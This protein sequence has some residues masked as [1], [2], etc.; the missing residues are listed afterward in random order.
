MAKLQ[1][2]GLS[3]GILIP[4]N[5]PFFDYDYKVKVSTH[6]ID[7]RGWDWSGEI[8]RDHA[9]LYD[10][11]ASAINEILIGKEVSNSNRFRVT[12]QIGL[13]YQ[14]DALDQG[15]DSPI[16]GIVYG[17]LFT[18][19]SSVLRYEMNDCGIGVMGNY[20][21]CAIPSWDGYEAT[22]RL[23]L[24]ILLFKQIQIQSIDTPVYALSLEQGINPEAYV[25]QLAAGCFVRDY[26][27]LADK[28]FQIPNC[29]RYLSKQRRPAFKR[30]SAPSA[31]ALATQGFPST[32]GRMASAFHPAEWITSKPKCKAKY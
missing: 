5:F 31:M 29:R 26:V 2:V 32:K 15:G 17:C 27:Q 25:A 16:G 3:F 30:I 24:S 22:D 1:K 14:L 8:Q 18:D 7:K 28:G 12:P 4:I 6:Q 13:G 10:K 23:S 21:P 19:F 9:G 11:H 20:Q